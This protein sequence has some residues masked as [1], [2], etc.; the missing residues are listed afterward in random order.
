MRMNHHQ[1]SIEAWIQAMKQPNYFSWLTDANL[2]ATLKGQVW[3]PQDPALLLQP[4][5]VL[6][7]NGPIALI[8]RNGDSGGGYYGRP[9]TLFEEGCDFINSGVMLWRLSP[10]T[11]K[12]LRHWYSLGADMYH[13]YYPPWEQPYLNW[14]ARDSKWRNKLIVVPYRELTGPRGMM[15]R[16]VWGDMHWKNRDQM[17][18][19]TLEMLTGSS[20]K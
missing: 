18:L 7:P 5:T 13:R 10:L 20:H 4:A 3:V 1:L 6:Q 8:P 16:H 19:D 17:V 9:D 2:T 14:V 11:F 12:F 15:V